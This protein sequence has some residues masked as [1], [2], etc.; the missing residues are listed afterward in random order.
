M[1]YTV[2]RVGS[3]DFGVTLSA[4]RG[5][6]PFTATVTVTN[7]VGSPWTRVGI[8]TRD[9]GIDDISLTPT[10]AIV[11]APVTFVSKGRWRIRIRAYGAN[12]VIL[13]ETY[14]FVL[15]TELLDDVALV[16]E[17]YNEMALQLVPG[18]TL[19]AL[20]YFTDE[21]LPKFRAIL[22]SLRPNAALF[23]A[24]ESAVYRSLGSFSVSQL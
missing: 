6:Y 24:T 22:D 16:E 13:F 4:D 5:R 11:S 20:H 12:N 17:A 9:Q 18:A 7:R 8:D 10:G 14:R 19:G 23:A 21:S 2:N 1:I 15:T 3:P